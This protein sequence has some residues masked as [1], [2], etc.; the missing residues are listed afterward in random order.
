[1]AN[2]SV[3]YTFSASTI[4]QSSQVNQ[5]FTDLINSLT[6]GSK[7][8]AVAAL[9]TG[10]LTTSGNVTLG[11]SASDTVTITGIATIGATLGVTGATTLSSTLNVSGITTFAKQI[12]YTTSQVA[13]TTTILQLT[14]SV[15]AVEITGTTATALH[16]IA[17]GTAGQRLTIFYVGM[18]TFTVKQNSGSATG[19]D[20]IQCPGAVDLVMSGGAAQSVEFMYRAS[21]S[22][23]VVIGRSA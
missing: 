12:V 2:P 22:Q 8:L 18:G 17:A 7:T 6:D 21:S 4:A 19:V 9:I 3:T 15:P 1:M 14:S 20:R 23:W 11:D 10:T 13:S 16:G 5:N